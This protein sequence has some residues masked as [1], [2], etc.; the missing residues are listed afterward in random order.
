MGARFYVYYR[1]RA[2]DEPVAVEAVRTMQAAWAS[3][4]P[5]LHCEVLR[6]APEHAVHVTL[7]EVYQREGGIDLSSRAAIEV[8]AN[9]TLARWL[10]GERHGE[11]FEPC[12]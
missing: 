12:A 11:V 8:D 7:M 1:V 5:G 6:R 10:I 9:T 3:T 2:A 4:L